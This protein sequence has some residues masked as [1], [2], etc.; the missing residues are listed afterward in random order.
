[1]KRALAICLLAMVTV[2]ACSQPPGWTSEEKLNIRHYFLAAEAD[3]A[4]VRLTNSGAAYSSM[5]QADMKELLRLRKL[6]LGEALLV[7]DEV[8]AKAHPEMPKHWRSEF[9]R[10][11]ELQIRDLEYNDP[12]AEAQAVVLHGRWVD[13]ANSNRRAIKIP[14][15]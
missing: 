14:R 1:M 8:L 7:R 10:S 3:I 9:Q 15:K 6:A 12:S 4:A 2:P 11:Q 13:W 5:S